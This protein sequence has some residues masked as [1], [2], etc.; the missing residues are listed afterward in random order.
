MMGLVLSAFFMN[1]GQ[2]TAGGI[3]KYA[4]GFVI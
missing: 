1:R 3:Y 2:E 4:Q